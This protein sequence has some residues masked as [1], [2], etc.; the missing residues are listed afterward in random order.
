MNV[1][2]YAM[3]MEKVAEAYYRDLSAQTEDEGLKHVM[4]MMA[5]EEAKH[6]LIFKKMAS[7]ESFELPVSTIVKD[8]KATF[9]SMKDS[10]RTFSF[11]MDQLH[12]YRKAK[13]LEDKAYA[14]Y[15][16]AAEKTADE[17]EKQALRKIAQEEL[18]HVTL[19]DN[20]VEFVNRPNQW[21]E[22]A[23]F[24]QMEEY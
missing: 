1:Y 16:D 15:T 22:N 4:D 14:Y 8:V 10:G 9:Q 20:I 17:N 19:L 6:Y 5:A 2:E 3:E 18:R 11:K 24:N 13:D 7:N 21:L 12:M 23:E